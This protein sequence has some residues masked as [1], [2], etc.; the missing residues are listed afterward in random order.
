M[1]QFNAPS[2]LSHSFTEII[3][4]P[5]PIEVQSTGLGECLSREGD[6]HPDRK[7]KSVTVKLP[8]NQGT[9]NKITASG[10]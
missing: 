5:N 10:Q 2:T 3:V 7:S 9:R 8:S 1:E 4:R 6:R